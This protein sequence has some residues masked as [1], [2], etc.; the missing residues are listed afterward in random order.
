M[1]L[2]GAKSGV[3]NPVGMAPLLIV[4]I[5]G[6]SASGPLMAAIT[7]PALA[8]A[9]WRNAAATVILAPSAL[10]RHELRLSRDVVWAGV[11]L[12]GHFATWIAA[13]KLTSVAAAIS[14]VSL[15]VVWV[16]LIQAF[17]G[18]RF[19]LA[20]LGGSVLA[21]AGVIVI[22]GVDF[23]LSRE[24]LLGDLLALGGGVFAAGYVVLGARVRA[25]STTTSYTFVCY[26]VCSIVL[27]A[28]AVLSR[29]D[30]V[31]FSQR[32]WLLIAAV[33][34]SAQLLGHSVVNHL[35]AFI[36]P[37]VMSLILLLEVPL[38]AMLAAVFL[39]ES[40][41][42]G[43]YGGLA[44]IVAGLVWVIVRRPVPPPPEGVDPALS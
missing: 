13:L 12:A 22:T 10:T 6:V 9:F 44:L 28:A 41:P 5:V 8:I 19:P 4:A 24:A 40:L 37:V 18:L 17:G 43:T 33:T 30:L 15:Q 11:L 38:A 29:T 16:A 36:A 2:G 27:L 3:A 7:A 20:V 31:G 23:A 21:I 26:G 39:S 34:V 42:I 35:L 32:D 1:N 14:L 25:V